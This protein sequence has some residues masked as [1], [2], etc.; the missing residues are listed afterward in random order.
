MTV[1]HCAI[2]GLGY[3]GRSLAQKLYEHGSHIAAIKRHLSSDDI[4]LP[5]QLEIADLNRTE[6]FQTASSPLWQHWADKPTWFCLLP[7]SALHDYHATLQQWLTLAEHFGVQHLI[8]SSSTSI[9][10]DR[11][12]LC[13]EHTAPE[14]QTESA[15]QILAVEQLL[16]NSRIPN[17]DILRFGGLYSAERH[18]VSRLILKK[19][20]SGGKQPVN[21]VHRDLAVHALFQT[22]CHPQGK[23]IRNIVEP[24]HPSRAEFYH[25]EAEKYGLPTP[26]FDPEDNR[27]GKIVT[28]LLDTLI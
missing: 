21:V 28:T 11:V 14:P 19:H 2:L 7:P 15:R 5:I 20:I 8:F 25:A 23:R 27:D 18:P 16:L 6:V 3:L 17:I 9:Y 10:G 4:N 22:A 12:R 26:D 24:N 1:P 13:N